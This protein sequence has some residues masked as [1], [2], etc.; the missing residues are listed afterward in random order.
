VTASPIRALSG[1]EASG[2]I[3]RRLE[4]LKK[5]PSAELSALPEWASEEDRLADQPVDI[6]TYRDTLPQGGLKIVVQLST[7]G[8]PFLRIFRAR[9]VFAEGFE[10]DSNGRIRDLA[11]NELYDFM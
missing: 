3:R 1:Q 6:T 2:A 7:R 10:I 8:E 9:Q 5:R 11:E 4:T